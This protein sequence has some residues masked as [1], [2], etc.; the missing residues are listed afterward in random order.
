VSALQHSRK[1]VSSAT[2]RPCAVPLRCDLYRVMKRR[3]ETFSPLRA[4]GTGVC[5]GLWQVSL[6]GP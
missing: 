5:F 4:L 2:F 1:I 6:K 3:T